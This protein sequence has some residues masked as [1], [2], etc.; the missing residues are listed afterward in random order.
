MKT[1][2]LSQLHTVDLCATDVAVIHQTPQWSTLGSIAHG[3]PPRIL[4]GFL[5]ITDGGCRYTWVGQDGRTERAEL[6]AGDLIYLPSGAVREVTTT[7]N[8]LSFYRISFRLFDRRDGEEILFLTEP[9]VAASHVSEQLYA[10]CEA[11]VTTT[12]SQRN[13]LKSLSLLYEF[14]AVTERGEVRKTARLSPALEHVEKHYTQSINVPALA[15]LC[16]MSVPHFFRLFKKEMGITPLEYRN[17]LRMKRSKEL[18][19]DGECQIGEIA[20]L[21]GFESIYYFSRAFKRAVGLSPSQY[22]QKH[23]VL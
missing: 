20:A 19:L 15:D 10:L 9:Y 7:Q 16:Y 17:E 3:G 18:L 21:V 13:N 12:L 2:P 11:L 6:T 22:R 14:L 23:G 8:P 1:L 5:L 4:N